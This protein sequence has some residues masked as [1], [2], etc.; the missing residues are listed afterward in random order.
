MKNCTYTAHIHNHIRVGELGHGLRNDGL[1]AP[2]SA[3]DGNGTTLDRG[4]QGVEHTLAD[5]EGPVG[6]LLLGGGTGHT[7]GP[8]LH[9]AV[10]GLLAVELDLED[11]LVDGVLA[12]GGDLGDGAAAARGEDD[13]VLG[14]E[15]V[16]VDD[17]PDVT[18]RDVVADLHLGLE[19][20]LLGAV[21]GGD[22]HSAGD[23]DALGGVGDLLEG[24]LDTIVDVV[25]QAWAQLDGE[26]L[27]GPQDGVANRH[28]GCSFLMSAFHVWRYGQK[29]CGRR[30]CLLVDLN[31]GLVAVDSDDFSHQLVV[32]DFHLCPVSLAAFHT[33]RRSRCYVIPTRT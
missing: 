7:D 23:V 24:S 5:N 27:S 14:D 10:L 4:E 8:C 31:G 6:G 17:T 15:R 26:G 18:A 9:H 19:L 28:T 32:A 2:E 11:L 20:P 22:G 1:A 33:Q 12:L 13:L 3:W 21:E 30:T 16:L 25:K 29:G